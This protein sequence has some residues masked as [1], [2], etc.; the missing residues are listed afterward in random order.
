MA[1]RATSAAIW[2]AT[3][4]PATTTAIWSA[5]RGA[6]AVGPASALLC[7]ATA[8]SPTTPMGNAAAIPNGYAKGLVDHTP[9]MYFPGSL[10]RSSFLYWLYRNRFDSTVHVWCFLYLVAHRPYY[11][12]NEQF[13]G[14]QWP[15]I[16]EKLMKSASLKLPG[17]VGLY[18]LLPL[19]FV[20]IPTS[21]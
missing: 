6:T 19:V 11:D 13:Y 21:L 7:P 2:S 16:V 14:Q 4:G 18:I 12:R 10:W 8:V 5:T 17:K 15:P 1:T 3:V 20:W 9:F